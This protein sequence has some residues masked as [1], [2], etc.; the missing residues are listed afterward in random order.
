MEY[1]AYGSLLVCALIL[2]LDLCCMSFSVSLSTCFLFISQLSIKGI[3]R[4][5]KQ[6]FKILKR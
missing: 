5:R 4:L 3:K 2:V 6:R 1:V